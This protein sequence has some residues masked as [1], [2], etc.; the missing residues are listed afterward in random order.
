MYF[1]YQGIERCYFNYIYT[2]S[3]SDAD[4]ATNFTWDQPEDKQG[5]SKACTLING[6]ISKMLAGKDVTQFKKIQD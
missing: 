4:D 1:S 5:M 2:Y 6:P 3:Q